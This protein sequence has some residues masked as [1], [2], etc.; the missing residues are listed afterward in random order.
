MGRVRVAVAG[1]GNCCSALV[2]GVHL[3]ESGRESIGLMHEE[4]GGYTASDIEFVLALDIDDRKVGKDLSEAIFAEPNNVP[5]LIRPS[6]QGVTVSMGHVLD[7]V[8]RFTE[9]LM[10]VS[11]KKEVDVAE[12]LRDTKADVLVDLISG[13][14]D[15]ASKFY[16][17]AAV[18]AGCSFLNATPTTIAGDR[19]FLERFRLAGLP[20]VG[21]DLLD[22]VGAT[23]VHMGLLEF[24][25]SRGVKIDESFQLDVGGGTESLNTLE[26]TREKKR[27]IKTK[28]VSKAIPYG[29]H[30]VS[31]STDYV[32]FLEN[33]RDSYFW[34]KG[35]YFGGAPF[36]MDV[37]LGTVDAPNGGGVL[38]DVIRAMKLAIDRGLCGA[39]LPLCAYGFK[40]PPK[41]YNLQE[42]YRLFSG[43]IIP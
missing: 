23:V 27:S 16:A 39:V 38:L 5:I 41:G 14:A 12:E 15:E 25:H 30:L 28:A 35:R 11:D 3:Y 31:G 20:I 42:A 7:S 10:S 43:F 32:D 6:K 33:S 36:T 13:G 21:D 9:G 18:E 19:A 34:M 2:Q 22:Q 24:L 1:V 40:S 26:M 37:R 4:V 29:F 17:E 8:G